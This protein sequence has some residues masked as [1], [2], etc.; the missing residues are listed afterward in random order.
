MGRVAFPT[1]NEM[2]VRTLSGVGGDDY[3]GFRAPAEP[4]PRGA[5]YPV[6]LGAI[7]FTDGQSQMISRGPFTDGGPVLPG[8]MPV[9]S[10]ANPPIK[11]C[12]AWGCGPPPIVRIPFTPICDHAAPPFGFHYQSTGAVDPSGCPG[13]ALI[14]DG[15]GPLPTPPAPPV[16]QQTSPTPTVI[17]PPPVTA[18]PVIITSGGGT[19]APAVAPAAAV[20]A[21]TGIMDSVAAW[22]SGSTAIFSYNVPNALLAGVVVLG[23]AWLEG[24]TGKKR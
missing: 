1:K 4:L 21:P 20:A 13:V 10:P 8:P 2:G 5:M 3:A 6:N 11:A 22:L 14:A 15:P 23:F 24:G 19:P 17:I 16:G 7:M 9:W 18:P 12:P